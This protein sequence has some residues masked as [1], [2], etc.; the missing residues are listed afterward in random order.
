MMMRTITYAF[1]CERH[2]S[3]RSFVRWTVRARLPRSFDVQRP[4][5]E[6]FS[7][8]V[9]FDLIEYFPLIW[10]RERVQTDCVLNGKFYWL[11]RLLLLRV[12]LSLSYRNDRCAW[13]LLPSLPIDRLIVIEP[14]EK[15]RG[16]V[17]AD[18]Q[19]RRRKI[20]M[21]VHFNKSLI[22]VQ[23]LIHS[24]ESKVRGEIEF[25]FCQY[26]NWEIVSID[27]RF[28]FSPPLCVINI[29]S[30]DQIETRLARFHDSHLKMTGDYWAIDSNVSI[31]TSA[32]RREREN[33]R[34]RYSL[35]V[36]VN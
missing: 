15:W 21:F 28:A 14:I 20:I 13:R 27:T 24:R 33:E 10:E 18:N 3:V 30:V 29:Q 35:H 17:G 23:V 5:T 2:V 26:F 34:S 12:C 25:V 22:Y 1:S 7:R 19:R 9:S 31:D 11:A 8:R 36:A 6:R 4:D 16:K 32:G